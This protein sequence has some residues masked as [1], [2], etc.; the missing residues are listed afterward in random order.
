MFSE[1][2]VYV[3]THKR[4]GERERESGHNGQEEEGHVDL[5]SIDRRHAHMCI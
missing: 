2:I 3:H 1:S 4:R 5:T